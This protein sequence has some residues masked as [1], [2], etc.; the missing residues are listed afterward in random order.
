MITGEPQGHILQIP[1]RISEG[2]E[3][4][5]PAHPKRWPRWACK[6]SVSGA[7]FWLNFRKNKAGMGLS[8]AEFYARASLVGRMLDHH[9]Y[10]KLEKF[11]RRRASVEV[12]QSGRARL[13]LSRPSRKAWAKSE[14]L[15]VKTADTLPAI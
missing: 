2:D 8:S 1:K 10:K 3:L 13:T 15:S 4:D 6:P 9:C 5:P 7:Q 14:V 12:N 11:P